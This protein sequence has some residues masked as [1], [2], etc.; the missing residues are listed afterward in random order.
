MVRTTIA[1]VSERRCFSAAAR[2]ARWP[3]AKPATKRGRSSWT[4]QRWRASPYAWAPG[5]CVSRAEHPK[6]LEAEF[7]S[8]HSGL[9]TCRRLPRRRIGGRSDY[10]A[11]EHARRLWPHSEQLGAQAQRPVAAGRHRE[12]GRGR[13]QPRSRPD[14]PSKRDGRR[15]G[16]RNE[17]G[18]AGR[19]RTR[20]HGADS[21]RRRR[22]DRVPAEG[23]RH[24]SHS[25]RRHGDID[26]KGLEKRDGVWINPE[27][28]NA[29]VTIRLDVKGGIGQ[30][31]LIRN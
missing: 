12:P 5:S 28:V 30:I 19:A 7:A 21:R 22:S 10:F 24:R 13:G 20:L 31:N 14:E 6:L 27:R 11:A 3:R 1:T 23:C 4:R 29:P 16:R 15:R 17:D 18:P 8:Q 26:V 2:P 9:E 25:H